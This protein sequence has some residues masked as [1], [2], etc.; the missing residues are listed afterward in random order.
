[1]L[2]QNPMSVMAQASKLSITQ[3]QQAIKNGTVPPYIGVPLLQQKIKES[4][5]AKQ[6]MAAQQPQQPPI[7]QQVMQQAEAQGVDTLPSN[8]P[9]QGMA[10]GG[11]IAFKEGDVVEDPDPYGYWA[12]QKR[13]EKARA[14]YVEGFKDIAFVG[15][16]MA[17]R[18]LDY[19]GD[20]LSDTRDK[21]KMVID[22]ETGKP[23]SVYELKRKSVNAVG[24][25]AARQY[26]TSGKIDLPANPTFN[27]LGDN[28]ASS[29]NPNQITANFMADAN[30]PDTTNPLAADATRG[31]AAAEGNKKTLNDYFSSM[32]LG[33]PSTKNKSKSKGIAGY[34]IKPYDDKELRAIYESELNP[35]TKQP[36]TYEEIADRNK[37]QATDAGID[38]DVYKTQREELKD[39]KEKYK[40]GTKL[41]EAMPFFA[42]AEALTRPV[43]SGEAPESFIGSALSGLGAYGRT[44]A[45]LT[46]KQ[47]AKLEKIR[48]EGNALALATNAFNQ[49]TYTGNKADLK[50]AKNSEKTA[51][52]NLANLGIKGVDQQNEVAKAV[53]DAGVKMSIAEMQERGAN[54]RYGAENRTIKELALIIQ[55]E[56]PDMPLDEVMKEA[57]RTKAA[58]SIYGADIRDTASQRTALTKQY[59]KVQTDF[60][61][62]PNTKAQQL[63]AIQAKL[64]ALSSGVSPMADAGNASAGYAGFVDRT[65][66]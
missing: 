27:L 18:G 32:D 24:K 11:I 13:A 9:V 20:V 26:R 65:K 3:L 30:K 63:R 5:Q 25:D 62:D 47:E 34:E 31:P 4:Q 45:E 14:P 10:G 46:D 58:G 57:Y 41:D 8:L 55:K 37:K 29:V 39:L 28:K 15:P 33:S 21:N 7:A 22:P 48:S 60:T 52:I 64:D 66:Y 56:H 12:E 61:L 38:F 54:S 6:A 23:I 2:N 51:R 44:S 42:A 1:M 59:E 35:V 17:G 53:Y 50:D 36:Y 43:K 19:L 40:K 49:A 16:R